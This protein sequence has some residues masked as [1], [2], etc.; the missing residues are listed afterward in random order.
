MQLS[1]AQMEL[2]DV[3]RNA[4]ELLARNDN[5]FFW[6]SWQD[7]NAAVAELDERITAIERGETPSKLDIAVL[8]A[9]TGP[10]QDVSISSGWAREFLVIASRFDRVAEAVWR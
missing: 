6:S 10:M 3:L 2:I 9:P 4:R 5:N 7:S 8:F 1:E